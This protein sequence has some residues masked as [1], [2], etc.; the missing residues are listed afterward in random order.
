MDITAHNK[1]FFSSLEAIL[2]AKS[3]HIKNKIFR[4][5]SLQVV[6]YNGKRVESKIFYRRKKI[7]YKS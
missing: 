5:Y 2:G 7:T 6:R 3:I 4:I 1:S